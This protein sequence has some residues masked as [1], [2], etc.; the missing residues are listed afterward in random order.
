MI[1]RVLY[2]PGGAGLLP[3][4]VSST[5]FENGDGKKSV[6]FFRLIWR[7]ESF[8]LV[9]CFV[10]LEGTEPFISHQKGKGKLSTHKC[11]LGWDRLPFHNH[12]G[13]KSPI[14][15]LNIVTVAPSQDAS[16]HQDYYIFNRESRNPERNLHLP[17]LL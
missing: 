15:R 13:G 17:L 10:T 5:F 1:Y 7:F 2:I 9:G 8:S 4:T 3:S 16:D 12:G 14:W 6:R 11:L